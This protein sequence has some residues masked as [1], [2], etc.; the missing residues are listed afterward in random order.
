MVLGEMRAYAQPQVDARI[1]GHL[2]HQFSASR[3]EGTWSLIDYDR[4]RMDLNARAGRNTRISAAIVYQLYRGDT[5]TELRDFLPD[6]LKARADTFAIGLENQHFLNHAYV[7]LRPGPFEVTAGKQ[8]LTWG[9]AWVFNPTELFRPKN[10]FEPTYDREGIAA[11]TV[12]LPLGSLSDVLVGLVPEEDFESSGKVLRARHHLAGFDLSAL[13]AAL[14]EQPAPEDIDVPPGSL[15]RRVTVGGDLSGE[16]FGLG[17]WAEATWSDHAGAQWMEATVGGNYTLADGTLLLL[18]GFYNGRGQWNDPYPINL[19]LGRFFGLQRT[20]GKGTLVG[21]VSRPVGQ[22]WTLGLSGLANVGDGSLVLIPSVAYAFAQ[23][24]DLL[25]NGL[26][27]AGP[28][29]TEFGL[30]RL[31]GFLRV[32]VY[33]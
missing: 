19:W 21:R 25:F 8:Y 6:D 9:A 15:E 10:A 22:L 12:R 26:V 2:E 32:R 23:D 24:V 18:E 11:V 29:G 13:V 1:N 31:G 20:L 14:H 7:T 33:F 16:L 27:Y 5:E 4:L 3:T 17:V 28:D 30:D